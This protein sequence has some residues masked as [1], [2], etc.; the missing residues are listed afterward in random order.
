MKVKGTYFQNSADQP[1][2][3]GEVETINPPRRKLRGLE[4]KQGII[5][6][7][8]FVGFCGTDFE[9]MHMGQRGQLN[10]KF[11]AGQ[12]RLINGH[13]GLVWV[14]S[15]NRFAIVLIRGGN[16]YDPTRYTEEES[17]FE[18]GCDGAD[19]LFS[20]MNYYHPDM[21]LKI[22]DGYVKDG[23][24]PLSLCKKLVFADPYAC[25]I[26]QR[27]RMEDLGEA[28]NFRVKMAQ[29]HC[30]E[31]EAREIARRETFQRVCIFG[32]GT[33]GMF[34]GDLIRQRYHDAKIVFVARSD[35]DSP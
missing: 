27:E 30:S 25:M 33:T 6:E 18:Y 8:A 24:I 7:S 34:I 9:L 1:L 31:S 2:V 13:E 4:E 15:E 14:P 22:P 3:Y 11:P 21:L 5:A 26:F 28:H 20:D 17:Y 35:E 12:K 16:S 29:Y 19:G 32:L 23:K 10:A